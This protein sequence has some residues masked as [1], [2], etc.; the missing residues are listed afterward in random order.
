MRRTAILALVALTLAVFTSCGGSKGAA[1]IKAYELGEYDKAQRI[2]LKAY[3]KEDDRYEKGRYSFY[4]GECYRNLRLFKKAASAYN[5]SVRYRYKDDN[6][7]M[8][9]GD[10]Y[11]AAGDY[12]QAADAYAAYLVKHENNLQAKDGMASCKIL[13]A[14]LPQI[15][16]YSYKEAPDSGYVVTLA[17]TF[18]SKYSDYSPMFAGDDYEVLYFTSMR[19]AKRRKKMNRITGQGNSNLYMSQIGI[20]GNWEK[21]EPLEDPFATEYD[22]GTPSFSADG[23][24]LYFTRCPYN[25]LGESTAEA[26]EVRRSGGRW[27]EPTRIF[28]GGDSIMMVAHPAI[29]PDGNTLYFVSDKE[30]GYGG[31][32]IYVTEKQTD[33]SWGEARNLGALINT[34]GDEMFPYVHADGTLYFASNGHVGLGGLDIYRVRT[35]ETGRYEVENMGFPINSP[36]DDF[37]IT[38]KGMREEGFFTSGRASGKGIDNI[39]SFSL[40]E[41]TFMLEGSVRDALG[42]VPRKAVV[43]I[44]GSD[45]T[46]IKLSP[47]DDGAFGQTLNRDVDYILFCGAKGFENQK[48]NFST[49]N[50]GRSETITYNISLRNVQK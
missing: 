34:K 27:G 4:L 43:R 35:T 33:G 7:L 24:T 23:K 31:K 2:L 47:N 40:P 30:K 10:C 39:Y 36:S 28:P 38:F 29:A 26:Y 17:R 8:Y 1:G 46:N 13:E 19:V 21:P 9:M 5:R 41:V 49:K 14:T 11:R 50:R 44:I 22:D 48:F 45:G 20:D 6:A 42:N 32:D 3:Q 18:N 16:S 37:G 25:P 12:S 15:E